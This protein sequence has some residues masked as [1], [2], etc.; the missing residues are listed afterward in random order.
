MR[1][2]LKIIGLLILG[3]NT[4]QLQAQD[5][6]IEGKVTDES[7]IAM[8]GDNVLVKG[9]NVGTATDEGGRYE[10]KVDGDVTL[11][12][13]MIGFKEVEVAT[14]EY[15]S[16]VINITMEEE[17]IGLD[18][19]TV[20]GYSEIE[21]EHV[22]SSVAKVDM[23][24]IETQTITKMEEA[25]SGTIPGVVIRRV[26]N[27]PGELVGSSRIRRKSTRQNAE[28]VVLVDGVEQSLN[29]LDPDN[30]EDITVLKDAS[31]AAMYG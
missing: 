17:T 14:R 7:D 3:L 1:I 5:R 30:M 25:F 18:E 31:P 24:K 29:D 2:I 11:I 15:D 20:V 10:I 22:A 12:F 26:H 21:T 27:I 8:S 4:V 19:V 13:S 9:T 6:T 23:E 28:H 16:N